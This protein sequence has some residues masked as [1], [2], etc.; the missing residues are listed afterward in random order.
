[1]IYGGTAMELIDDR[2]V[3]KLITMVVEVDAPDYVSDDF[4]R[5]E[6]EQEIHCASVFSDVKSFYVSEPLESVDEEK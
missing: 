2:Y 6:I 4:I 5:H 3:K 1:M